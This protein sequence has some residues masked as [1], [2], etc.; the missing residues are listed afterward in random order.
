MLEPNYNQWNGPPFDEIQWNC[1]SK[2]ENVG[3]NFKLLDPNFNSYINL[4][5][6]NV[7]IKLESMT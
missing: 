4:K 3:N 5:P 1:P 6:L 2:P 7:G